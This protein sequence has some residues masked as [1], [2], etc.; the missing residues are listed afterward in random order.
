MAEVAGLVVGAIALADLFETCIELFHQFS[1]AK[2]CRHDAEI[3]SL[4]LNL[5][6]ALYLQWAK[7]I[8]LSDPDCETSLAKTTTGKL[9]R[10]ILTKIHE[11]LTNGQL[12]CKRYGLQ[13]IADQETIKFGTS[14]SKSNSGL[15]PTNRGRRDGH[16]KVLPQ[17]ISPIRK[18]LWAIHDSEKFGKLIQDLSYFR[19]T[20]NDLVPRPKGGLGERIFDEDLDKIERPSVLSLIV[21]V[22]SGEADITLRAKKKLRQI[23]GRKILD[24]L[25]FKNINDRRDSISDAYRETFNWALSCTPCCDFDDLTGFLRS[26]ARI[27]W[28]AGKPGS[29]KSTLMKYIYNHEKTERLLRQ[30][31]G[32]LPCHR[33]SFFFFYLGDGAEHRSQAGLLRTLLYELLSQMPALAPELLPQT[34]KEIYGSDNQKA[35]IPSNTEIRNAFAKLADGL[36]LPCKWCLFVDGLDEF[37]GDPKAIAQIVQ[38]IANNKNIKLIVSSRPLTTFA[39][40]FQDRPQLHIDMLTKP[41]IENFVHDKLY[42]HQYMRDMDETHPELAKIIQSDLVNKASGVFLWVTVACKSVLQGFDNSDSMS[43]IQCRID[44]LPDELEQLFEHILERIDVRYRTQARKLLSLRCHSQIVHGD[45]PLTALSMAIAAEFDV[46]V[47]NPNT[48]RQLSPHRRDAITDGL[49]NKLLS[50]CCGMLEVTDQC[51]CICGRVRWHNKWV[52][53]SV[54]FLHRTVFDFLQMPGKLDV[55]GL[56]SMDKTFDCGAVLSCVSLY[57]LEMSNEIMSFDPM[58][59]FYDTLRYV[60]SSSA[61]PDRLLGTLSELIAVSL[62]RTKTDDGIFFRRLASFVQEPTSDLNNRMR[63]ARLLAVEIGLVSVISGIH[64][65][66]EKPEAPCSPKGFPLLYHVIRQ[67]LSGLKASPDGA[68]EMIDHLLSSGADP[69]EVFIGV[70]GEDSTLWKVWLDTM[71]SDKGW[72]FNHDADITQ[73]FLRAGADIR[74]LSSEGRMLEILRC[75]YDKAI[76]QCRDVRNEMDVQERWQDLQAFIHE[77]FKPPA[78]RLLLLWKTLGTW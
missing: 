20:L 16:V 38:D 32:Q 58:P 12:M 75:N 78:T 59:F 72:G 46:N 56:D 23:T 17:V 70:R 68:V 51:V 1:L 47:Y 26:E 63:A 39:S 43:E 13:E 52:H 29:G 49:K 33:A 67:P 74:T 42:S 55:D 36:E 4:K 8:G 7:D 37:D 28:I 64:G 35:T 65:L 48:A 40:A 69:N 18:I 22:A 2:S 53:T 24:T 41:D 19:S 54:D 44:E 31:A 9:V 45:R 71:R 60:Q 21:E 50:R 57:L 25:W 66:E 10:H 76:E 3:L 73:L 6:K 30:W 27:Y 11:L 15:L 5:E 77:H 61:S 14:S 62:E 34:W